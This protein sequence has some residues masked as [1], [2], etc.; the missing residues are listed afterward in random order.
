MR[1]LTLAGPGG[2]GK[3]SRGLRV[4]AELEERFADGV[5]FM[6]LAPMTVPDRA[7]LCQMYRNIECVMLMWL[8]GE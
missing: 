1:L 7:S 8:F 5:W 3:T 4:A 2:V 6:P